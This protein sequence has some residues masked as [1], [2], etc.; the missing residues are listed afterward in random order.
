MI[1]DYLFFNFMYIVT[2]VFIIV[3]THDLKTPYYTLSVFLIYFVS[4]IYFKKFFDMESL[5][6]PELSEGGIPQK[7]SS[8]P[9]EFHSSDT[10]LHNQEVIEDK[11]S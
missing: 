5:R 7:C 1:I 6:E 8:N 9:K 10:G 3:Y 11:P 2:L 4:K